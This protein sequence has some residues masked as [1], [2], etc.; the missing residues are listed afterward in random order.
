[1]STDLDIANS[2]LIKLGQ[3]KISAFPDTTTKRGITISEQFSKVR[4]RL[5]REHT[6]SFATKRIKLAV[7][8]NEIPASDVSISGDTLTFLK[9]GYPSGLKI[10]ISTDDT[11]PTGLSAS[12]DYF[13]IKNTVDTFKLATSYANAIATVP[14]PI[15]ITSQGSGTHTITPQDITPEFGYDS[16]MTLPSDYIKI[17]K[18]TSDADG[19]R[20]IDHKLENGKLLVNESEC[21]ILYTYNV[22]DPSLFT[23][24][25]A[26]CFSL[27]LAADCAYDIVQSKELKAAL[28]EESKAL[29]AKTKF[30]NGYESTQEPFEVDLYTL[31]RY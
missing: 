22:S 20:N 9:H 12:T 1:M 25:F 23:D 29:L 6:W 5:I 24:D 8:V 10:Q 7:T 17:F 19:L 21:Y 30:N 11:L 2:A 14:V 4:K 15:N 31:T 26:E 3:E 16:Q 18:V 28:S 27:E 13:I